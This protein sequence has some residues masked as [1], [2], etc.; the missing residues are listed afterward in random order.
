MAISATAMPWLSSCWTAAKVGQVEGWLAASEFRAVVVFL[1][2]ENASPL[3]FLGCLGLG[4]GRG[5]HERNQRIPNRLLHRVLGCAIK[6]HAV[7]DGSDNHAT[8]H[9]LADGVGHVSVVSAEAVH[10][11]NNEGI[12]RPEHIE[13]PP[14]L[15]PVRE[16]GAHAGDAVVR[17][18]FVQV[19]ARRLG[20]RPLV[21]EGLFGGADPGVENGS[22]EPLLFVRRGSVL[23]ELVRRGKTHP[24]GLDFGR[25]FAVHK[26]I[27]LRTIRK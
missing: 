16:R 2:V 26:P 23:W 24:S 18:D 9:E 5:R 17:H 12:A 6:H 25:F 4:L 22:P 20:L 15:G 3:R 21:G 10:P 7:D 1:G 13:Q 8:A 27:P 14:P 19:E 11:T